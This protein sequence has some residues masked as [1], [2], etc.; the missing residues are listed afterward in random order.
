[1]TTDSDSATKL[2]PPISGYLSEQMSVAR[3]VEVLERLQFN[4][5]EEA[6]LMIDPGVQAFLIRASRAAAADHLDA[7]V[8]HAWR[9]IRPP[10]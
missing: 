5:Q 7:K 9:A 2:A 4:K 10:R 8:R 3:M 6:R 1:M